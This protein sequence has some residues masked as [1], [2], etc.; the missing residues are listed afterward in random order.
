MATRDQVRD[1]LRRQPFRPFTIKLVDGRKFEINHPEFVS[2]SANERG[3]DLV[4][5]EDR[6]H[7][8]DLLHV[9]E[10]EEEEQA[11]TETPTPKVEGNGDDHP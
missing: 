5:H 6:M 1:A 2:V 9:T 7:R 10:V 11:E 4:I 8:I 3:R